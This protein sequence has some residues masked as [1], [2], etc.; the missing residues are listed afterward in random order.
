MNAS[1]Y[2]QRSTLYRKLIHGPHGKLPK[3]TPQGCPTKA[4]VGNVPG[5]H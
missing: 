3:F 1:D 2:L 4:W 5:D